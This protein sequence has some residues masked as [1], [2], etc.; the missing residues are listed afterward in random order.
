MEIQD[1]MDKLEQLKRVILD[2]TV[3]YDWLEEQ[4]AIIELN[5]K[6]TLTDKEV[7]TVL[8][9]EN[10]LRSLDSIKD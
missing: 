9:I 5:G 2:V 7:H 10:L 6:T 4:L 3:L 8:A 1:T